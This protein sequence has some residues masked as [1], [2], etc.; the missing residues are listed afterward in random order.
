MTLPSLDIIEAIRLIGDDLSPA[1]ATILR[2]INGLALPEEPIETRFFRDGAFVRERETPAEMFYRCTGRSSYEPY[3]Y[4]E[5]TILPGRQ[6]GKTS[7]IVANQVVYEANFRPRTLGLGDEPEGIIVSRTTRQARKAYKYVLA[8]QMS[9]LLRRQ[10]RGVAQKREFTLTNGSVV[11][12]WP[13]SAETTRGP[14]AFIVGCDEVSFWRNSETNAS[15]A[16]EVLRAL[17]PSLAAWEHGKLLKISTPFAKVPGDPIWDDFSTRPAGV[18]VWNQP[19]WELNPSLRDDFLLAEFRRDE[20]FFWR[21]YGAQ[22]WESAA[23]FLPGQ[24]V[25]AAVVRGRAEL[26]PQ[27]GV[28]YTGALDAAFKSGAFAFCV[29]HRVGEKVVADCLRSWRGTKA[30][31]VA[32]A[33]TLDEICLTLRRYAISKIYGDS[34]C[35]EPIKQALAAKGVQFEQACTLGARASAIW[36]TLRTLFVSSRIELLDHPASVAE[37]KRLE[38]VVTAGGNSRIEAVT[39]NDDLAVVLALAAHEA[40]SQPVREPLCGVIIG[41]VAQWSDEPKEKNLHDPFNDFGFGFR[42]SRGPVSGHVSSN[43]E[44]KM[45]REQARFLV[46]RAGATYISTS[47]DVI[48]FSIARAATP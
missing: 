21:E 16:Q 44:A 27:P 45:D 40:V 25:D 46:D 23:M 6:S 4:A 8:R 3:E 30:R 33:A 36:G 24:L 10:M 35:S 34:F 11:A 39:G 32:L 7:K 13:C 28:M 1:Q 41:G 22:F 2:A 38:Q 29:V 31:P 18:L 15:P 42:Q 26:P 20:E 43:G 12:V 17:R 48:Y 14:G 19:S 5:A 9:K 37:L 47:A